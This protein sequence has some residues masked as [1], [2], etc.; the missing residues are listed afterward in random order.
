MFQI[1]KM[2]S[3]KKVKSD[4]VEME[5]SVRYEGELKALKAVIQ[6]KKEEIDALKRQA[7]DDRKKHAETVKDLKKVIDDDKNEV[8]NLKKRHKETIES[9][10][11]EANKEVDNL[12]RKLHV[13]DLLKDKI[14]CPVCMEIPRKGPVLVCS[15]G[16]VVCN[17]C[18]G[19]A[20][21]TCRV[22]M[23]NGRSLLAETIL[24]N[25]DHG[26]E[27]DGCD[28]C[29][30]VYKIEQHSKV[31]SHRN[32]SCPFGGCKLKV[33]LSKF[34]D[35]LNKNPCSYDSAPKLIEKSSDIETRHFI[36]NEQT[37]K[38]AIGWSP[39]YTFSFEDVSFGIFVTKHAGEYCFCSVMFSSEEECSK[40]KIDMAVHDRDST[41]EA[42]EACFKLV[43]VLVLNVFQNH[44]ITCYKNRQNTCKIKRLL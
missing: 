8:K 26:C 1:L 15:N 20:C 37:K 13:V 29:F 5:E 19:E 11:G 34:I 36:V 12:K 35:H 24:E 40:Y 25:I 16:H 27:F 23:G 30:P 17:T 6:V 38:S 18:K 28:E 22:Q 7:K 42:S 14:E 39:L 21:H 10:T 2:P 4:S 41:R 9:L 3:K 44:I 33:G 43:L 31:C 32:V